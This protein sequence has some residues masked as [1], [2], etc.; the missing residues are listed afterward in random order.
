MRRCMRSSL[1]SILAASSLIVALAPGAA[2]QA[3]PDSSVASPTPPV[4]TPTPVPVLDRLAAAERAYAELRLDD[5]D[6]EIR[7][8]LD[9]LEDAGD[10]AITPQARARA[11]VLAAS[12]ARARG[13]LA[14][15]DAA[16]DAALSVEPA[17]R[18]DPALHPPPLIEA[19]ERRRALRPSSPTTASAEEVPVGPAMSTVLGP[20]VVGSTSPDPWPWVGLGVGIAVLVGGAITL[21]VVLSAPPSSFDV[22]G[23]IVP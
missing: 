16:L 10:P 5:A 1:G 12:I 7:A 21:S 13:D 14:A 19:L 9:Q 8:V 11:H 18:L 22:R 4:P 23:T 2:A 6:A 20:D 3:D 15:S 17:L